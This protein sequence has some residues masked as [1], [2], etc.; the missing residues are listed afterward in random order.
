MERIYVGLGAN[1]GDREANLRSAVVAIE[2]RPEVRVVGASKVYESAPVGYVGQPDY[3][4]AA[5]EL[6]TGVSPRDLLRVLLEIERSLGRVRE[7]RWGPRIIDLD[8]LLYG[9]RIVQEQ[10]LTVPHPQLHL[11]A[12]V[13]LPLLDLSPEGVEPL[14]GKRFHSLAEAV[15]ADSKIRCVEGFSLLAPE[16]NREPAGG[17]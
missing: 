2:A 16:S 13:L 12:F 15:I 1:V 5:G 3:L 7:R 8:L 4:N 11:R 6:E 17:R 14:T 9:H 10:G